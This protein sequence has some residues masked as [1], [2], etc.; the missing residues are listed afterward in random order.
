LQKESLQQNQTTEDILGN[1]HA[2]SYS[3]SFGSPQDQNAPETPSSC[4]KSEIIS[5]SI[6][7]GVDE[8]QQLPLPQQLKAMLQQPP[9]VKLIAHG[10]K[11][12]PRPVYLTLHSDAIISQSALQTPPEYRNC[13]TWRAELKSSL[14]PLSSNNLNHARAKMGNLRKVELNEI[15]GFELG[16]RTTALRRVQTAR[17]INECDCFSLLTKTGTL[18]LECTALAVGGR[19]SSA[20]EVRAAFITCLAMAVSSRLRMDGLQ[21]PTPSLQAQLRGLNHNTG[22]PPTAAAQWDEG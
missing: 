14:S 9:G 13:L 4:A 17:M 2:Y 18:D 1:V 21:P 19:K 8:T 7:G 12:R 15:L 16:K 5:D 20:E 22:S 3:H 11:C 10:T 6:W